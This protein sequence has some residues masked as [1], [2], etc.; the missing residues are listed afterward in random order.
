M[1]RWGKET[2]HGNPQKGKIF[3]FDQNH[4]MTAGLRDFY[5]VDELWEKTEIH[6][7]AKAI[8]SLSWTDEGTGEHKYE[9]ALFTSQTGKGRSFY[10][11]S[12]SR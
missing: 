5:I 10:T 8:A 2:S 1:G 11:V 3:E 9:K 6:P 4:P 12:G 7:D